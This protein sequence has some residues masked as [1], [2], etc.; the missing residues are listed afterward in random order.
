MGREIIYSKQAIK[1][2]RKQ[3]KT[4]QIRLVTAINGLP[5]GDVKKMQGEDGF[6][7]RVGDFRVIY[8]EQG[9]ILYIIRIGN[10]GEFY[11]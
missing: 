9:H 10:R 3:D 1:F 2:I 6:R 5:R 4:T 8:D 11:K 7:L